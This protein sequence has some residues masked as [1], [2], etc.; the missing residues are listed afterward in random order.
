M[1]AL[2][3]CQYAL[4][5]DRSVTEKLENN[6][7]E[8]TIEWDAEVNDP[9]LSGDEVL[10]LARAA[11]P[12][13]KFDKV[14]NVGDG[15]SFL[16]RVYPNSTAR[17]V[18]CKMDPQS[19]GFLFKIV[20]EFNLPTDGNL[21][22]LGPEPPAHPLLW[23]VI[24]WLEI[25][26][27]QEVVEKIAMISNLPHIG[28][29]TTA[30]YIV[31][32]KKDP[33]PAINAA[34]QQSI[35]PLLENAHRIILNVQLYFPNELYAIALNSQFEKTV[36]CHTF[37]Y[38]DP[39][40][41]TYVPGDPDHLD[42]PP[43]VFGCPYYTWKY[44]GAIPDKPK[45]RQVIPK[46]GE[47]EVEGDDIEIHEGAVKYTPT[48]VRF[49]FKMGEVITNQDLNIAPLTGDPTFGFNLGWVKKLLNNGQTC[50]K[51]W[52]STKTTIDG[53]TTTEV[54]IEDPRYDDHRP[55]TVPTTA[56]HLK[57]AFSTAFADP[58]PI[59]GTDRPQPTSA[60][61]EEEATGE[62]INL[63]LDGTQMT[64]P[65]SKPTYIY[66]LDLKP[67]NYFNIT[68]YF[69]NPIFSETIELPEFPLTYGP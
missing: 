20:A 48:L 52:Q 66:G 7:K 51:K 28:R 39:A 1:S 9:D 24:G 41:L 27:E 43:L 67:A 29:G 10:A 19:E 16:G 56:K 15:Y 64:D 58:R 65:L 55:I 54:Y 5:F 34:N 38:L 37:F 26:E 63:H 42:Y 44:L 21:K 49:E 11:T 25:V 62:P 31:N 36:H 61:L 14:I 30:A 35:D 13:P 8:F 4:E 57:S 60:D 12:G 69:G 68:D 45:W 23:P 22:F 50:F 33:G 40:A 47:M 32:P 18:S 6:A 53:P 2:L 3:R 59:S 17:T 46:E